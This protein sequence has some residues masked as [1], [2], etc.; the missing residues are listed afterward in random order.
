[1]IFR[2]FLSFNESLSF[3]FNF[4]IFKMFTSVGKISD[5]CIF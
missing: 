1:M 5:F 3:N 2:F 4:A